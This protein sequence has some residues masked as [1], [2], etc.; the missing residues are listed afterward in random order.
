MFLRE[1]GLCELLKFP[2]GFHDLHDVELF[3]KLKLGFV[4]DVVSLQKLRAPQRGKVPQTETTTEVVMDHLPCIMKTFS[5]Q[6]TGEQIVYVW[7]FDDCFLFERFL[8]QEV[9]QPQVPFLR[10]WFLTAGVYFWEYL[11][12]KNLQLLR[13]TLWLLSNMIYSSDNVRNEYFLGNKRDSNHPNRE[14]SLVQ[15]ADLSHQS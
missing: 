10:F 15:T 3:S 12:L 11:V 1:H 13:F 7:V 14:Q 6:E 8:D 2:K 5:I 4:E 9:F